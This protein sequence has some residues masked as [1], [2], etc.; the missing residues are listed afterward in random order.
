MKRCILIFFVLWVITAFGG[1]AQKTQVIDKIVIDPGHGG[2]KPG[3]IGSRSKEK[4][5]T[6]AVSLK[7]G[8]LIKDNLQGVDVLFTRT[9][10][11]DIDLYKRSQLANKSNADLFISIHCN[12]STSK[13]SKG[14]ETFAMGFAKTAENI[15]VAKKENAEILTELNYQKNYD[16]FDPNAP[17]NNILFSLYQTAYMESSLKFAD[18]IQ[19]QFAAN[20]TMSNRGV[21]QANFVVLFQSAMPSVLIEIG[22]IS[23]KQE[24]AYLLSDKGQY[25]IAG[26]ILRAIYEYKNLKDNTQLT[27]PKLQALIPDSIYNKKVPEPIITKDTT[28]ATTIDD[29]AAVVYRVQMLSLPEKVALND[30]RFADLDSLWAYQQD[31]IWKYTAGSFN[32]YGLAA[33]YQT[34]LKE[35]GYKDAFVVAFY[36][37]K[38]ISL[39]EANKLNK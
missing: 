18:L 16:G 13:E 32:R 38:R 21:K 39:A 4:E 7:L 24:E 26:S 36:K 11:K 35:R 8:Q 34:A 9:T 23:N 14:F 6:L 33:E 30:S 15:A 20:T 28:T 2:D 12:S 3:A 10:D 31:G 22:F 27:I 1:Y 29:T 17:E 37:G 19:K 25:E 5:I